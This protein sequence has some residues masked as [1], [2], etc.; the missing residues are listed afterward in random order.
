MATTVKVITRDGRYG[1]ILHQHGDS[2]WHP[3]NEKHSA[4]IG[5]ADDTPE[6]HG[7]HKA[8]A[9]A[10]LRQLR[11]FVR[12]GEAITG[13]QLVEEYLAC[14]DGVPQ[15][16]WHECWKAK[17]AARKARAAAAVKEA[18]AIIQAAPVLTPAGYS[19]PTV[20]D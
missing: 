9:P 20:M 17:K 10:V 18:E 14:L 15:A 11:S 7:I 8:A 19:D 6:S 4:R 16:Y 1:L 2:A 12:E 13:D 3:A 5:T